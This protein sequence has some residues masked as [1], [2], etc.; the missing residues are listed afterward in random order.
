MTVEQRSKET[1]HQKKP[2][3]GGLVC[4]LAEEETRIRG[5]ESR[6][7]FEIW[8]NHHGPQVS[9]LQKPRSMMPPADRLRAAHVRGT[10]R[11]LNI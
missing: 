8:T 1:Q 9:H 11:A 3:T 5:R 6:R 2:H 10:N 7:S 4:G